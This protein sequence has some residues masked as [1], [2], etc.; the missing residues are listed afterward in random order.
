MADRSV[1]SGAASEAS[2]GSAMESSQSWGMTWR[3]QTTPSRQKDST[4]SSEIGRRGS[5][6][7]ISRFWLIGRG[8]VSGNIIGRGVI[9]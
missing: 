9:L 8:D 2:T 3:R 5:G 4:S 7:I 6:C 1:I